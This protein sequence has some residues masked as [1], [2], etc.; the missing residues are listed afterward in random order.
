MLEILD[1]Q[2]GNLRFPYN[3]SLDVSHAKARDVFI[4]SNNI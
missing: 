4:R 2:Q 1:S 3:P